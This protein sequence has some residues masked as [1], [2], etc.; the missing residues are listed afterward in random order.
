[1]GKVARWGRGG[2]GLGMQHGDCDLEMMASS[3]SQ[4]QD[5][6]SS[7]NGIKIELFAQ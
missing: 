1:M 2:M 4:N 6:G 7:C 5:K 3:R